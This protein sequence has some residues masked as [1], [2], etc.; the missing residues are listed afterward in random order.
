MYIKTD[1]KPMVNIYNKICNIRW[2]CYQ[3]EHEENGQQAEH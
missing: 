1:Y 2:S 3:Q